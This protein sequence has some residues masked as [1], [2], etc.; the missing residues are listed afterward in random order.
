MLQKGKFL[1]AIVF[2]IFGSFFFIIALLF[3]FALLSDH[4]S[5]FINFYTHAFITLILLS[6]AVVCIILG[7][8]LLKLSKKPAKGKRAKKFD[9]DSL[10]KIKRIVKVS[11]RIEIDMMRE[12][13]KMKKGE[14]L[15]KLYI[16][17]EKFNFR[18][19]G[20]T[21]VINKDTVS[22]FLEALDQQFDTWE[23]QEASENGKI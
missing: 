23:N 3:F 17:A 14:F 18:I 1:G 9:A 2:F 10:E 21:L 19:D 15:D 20:N 22:D 12:S 5:Y 16:W 13:L 11:D 4:V 6:L 8:T 7:L